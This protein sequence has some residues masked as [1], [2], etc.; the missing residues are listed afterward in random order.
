MFFN[1]T[2]NFKMA[3]GM[4][5][6]P[7]IIKVL[8]DGNFRTL[9][10]GGTIHG[11]R[12]SWTDVSEQGVAMGVSIRIKGLTVWD[13][14]L[15]LKYEYMDSHI[16]KWSGVNG[17]V[18][19][20]IIEEDSGSVFTMLMIVCGGIAIVFVAASAIV[21]LVRRG[22]ICAKLC[23]RE[24]VHYGGDWKIGKDSSRLCK[25]SD[26]HDNDVEDGVLSEN[27]FT[28]GTADIEK[29]TLC[30]DNKSDTHQTLMT[31]K[32]FDELITDN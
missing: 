14:G 30:L 32:I 15:Y 29:M 10:P 11:H 9:E 27:G 13:R 12:I 6:Q 4:D 23:G 18:V 8:M 17:V 19:R 20:N 26:N 28:A 22:I 7:G 3:P 2:D 24:H 5:G 21:H 25:H 16:K 31:E 1:G